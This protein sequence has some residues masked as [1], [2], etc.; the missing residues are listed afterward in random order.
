MTAKNNPFNVQLRDVAIRKFNG[1]DY[2]SIMPQVAEFTLYQSVF[3]NTIKADL[4]INDFIGLMENYPLSAEEVV[5]V[6][7]SQELADQGDATK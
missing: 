5:E 2:M 7:V 3:E 4:V 6:T 1:T